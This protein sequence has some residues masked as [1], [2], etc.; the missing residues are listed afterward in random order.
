MSP[1][2]LGLLRHHQ[3]EHAAAFGGGELDEPGPGSNVARVAVEQ[4]GDEVGEPWHVLVDHGRDMVVG[5]DLQ[6]AGATVDGGH[7][8]L[9]R[10]LEDLHRG[11]FKHG[12]LLDEGR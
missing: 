9:D 4:H 12:G 1:D 10:G 2:V 7:D 11:W 6:G 3:S 5:M 8:G